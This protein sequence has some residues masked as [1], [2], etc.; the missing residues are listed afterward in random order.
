M[1]AEVVAC[2]RCPV[3]GQALATVARPGHDGVPGALHCPRG[4]SFN[5]AKQGYVDLTAGAV[6]HAGDSADMVA[7]RAEFLG[8][9]HY[10]FVA[11]ELAAAVTAATTGAATIGRET[12]APERGTSGAVATGAESELSTTDGAAL[13]VDAGAGT[14]AHLATVLDAHPGTV[15][16]A[17][18]V[19]RYALRRAARA[20]P[21]MA[22]ARCDVWTSLPLADH[23]AAVLLNVF[24]PRNGAEFARVLRPDGTLLV[25]TPGPDHLREL[26]DALD[27]LR[28]DPSKEDRLSAS[29]DRWF[30][31][32]SSTVAQRELSLSHAEVET[33]V[34]MGPSAWHAGAADRAVRIE[35]L[36]EPVR[37]TAQVRIGRYS[38]RS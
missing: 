9:G 32:V 2:L 3:C 7:A 1:L 38:P 17:L 27:L 21:R 28:V 4:H 34:G 6:P 13:I 35:T 33:L 5:R 23:C 37:V 29:L 24:A 15:G 31:P 16:L 11:A 30:A 8:A 19:S 25:V 12:A 20:H 36:T 14:G 18:D 22:A 10:G 26:V